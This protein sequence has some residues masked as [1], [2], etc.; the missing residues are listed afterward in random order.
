MHRSR[1]SPHSAPRVLLQWLRRAALQ[2]LHDEIVKPIAVPATRGAWYRKWRLISLDGS[3]LDVADQKGNAKAF[4]GGQISA[5]GDTPRE[6]TELFDKV[7]RAVLRANMCTRC[8]ICVRA[9]P[10]HA[11]AIDLSEPMVIDSGLCNQCGKCSESCVVAHYFDKLA[12][13]APREE[14]K[15]GNRRAA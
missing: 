4:A 3:T 14:R 1:H 5:V 11:I 7:A 12:G 9:C 13:E 6:A 15:A 2:Q 8:G 10:T